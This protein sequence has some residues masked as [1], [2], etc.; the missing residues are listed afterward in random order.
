[1]PDVLVNTLTDW[2]VDPL[3]AVRS[4]L[5]SNRVDLEHFLV[6]RAHSAGMSSIFC[7]PS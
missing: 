6:T 1:L 2:L 3:A 5:R 7:T 4:V